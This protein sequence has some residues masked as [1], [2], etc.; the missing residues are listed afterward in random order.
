MKKIITN[1]FLTLTSILLG[2]LVLEGGMRIYSGVPLFSTVNFVAR[3]LDI[4]RANTMAL[5]FDQLL[6]WRLKDG[7]GTPESS[8]STTRF[9]IRNNGPVRLPL[10]TKAVLAVGDSFTV[11]SGVRDEETWPAQLEQQISKPVINGAAGGW[12]VDQMVLRA[13]ML[14]ETFTP[15]T[16]IVGILGQDSLRNSFDLY[17]GGFK[18]WFNVIDGKPVLQGVP[19]PRFENSAQ[20]LSKLKL[21]FGHSWL[22]QWT[23]NR[24]GLLD[25]WVDNASRYRS[26]MSNEDGVAVS[27]ALMQRLES[28]KN[29]YGSKIIVVLL[30]S[31]QESSET[32]APWY[33]PPVIEC[34]R[35]AGFG[36]L[37]L[38]P[39]LHK[40]SKSDP[41]RFKRLWIDENGV[42]GHP[43][44]EGNTITAKLLHEQFFAR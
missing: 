16:I 5:D 27:C 43:S 14:S 13:E 34:A 28:L 15:S 40:I 30:W 7:I 19:V 37:D 35:K 17:G 4:V 41:N 25:R 36:V 3:S 9:G 26:V 20:N 22:V 39:V 44:P 10:T 11:G 21:V 23:M 42:L 12:G 33:G 38:Y 2:F 18:P 8:F 6:G 32:K 31:A 1:T 24:L 29:H